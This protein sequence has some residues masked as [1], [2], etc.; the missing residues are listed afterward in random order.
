M[1]RVARE[2][3]RV[4]KAVDEDDKNLAILN[5]LPQ[6]YAVER[7]LVKGGDDE[8]TWAHIENVVLNQYDRLQA[9]KFETGTKALAVV[10]MPEYH[11]PQPAPLK[12]N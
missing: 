4:E 5:G 8:P 10:G 1:L 2:L 11:K 7:L 12:S 3:R 9:E 6:D